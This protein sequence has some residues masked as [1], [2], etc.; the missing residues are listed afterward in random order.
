MITS[1]I[2]E[3]LSDHREHK[4]AKKKSDKYTDNEQIYATT[5]VANK[6]MTLQGCSFVDTFIPPRI[7]T[8]AAPR[9]REKKFEQQNA[10]ERIKQNF[11]VVFHVRLCV[12]VP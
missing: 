11:V 8:T 9:K 7:T 2:K 6:T 1:S 3:V 12:C 4:C 10:N 5:Y